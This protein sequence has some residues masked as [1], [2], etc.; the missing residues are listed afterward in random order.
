VTVDLRTYPV[1]RDG[2]DI[3]LRLAAAR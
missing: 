3:Y 1:K 2:E